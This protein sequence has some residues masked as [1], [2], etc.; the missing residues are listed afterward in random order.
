MSKKYKSGLV[1]GKFY[2]LHLGHQYIIDTAIENC[3]H[4]HVIISHN[5]TQE[6][7]GELRFQYLK[8]LY[9]DN[10]SV[11][12]HQF[13][14][15]NF[16]KYDYE[17]DTLDEFYS[18]WVPAIKSIVNDLDVVFTSEDYGDDF[19]R[20][21]GVKHHLVDRE[22]SKYPISGTKVRA[23]PFKEWDFINQDQKSFF[24]KRIAIMGP[25]S[26]GKSTLS[27][28]LSNYFNT[29]FVVEYGRTVF[30]SNGNSVTLKDFVPISEGRQ[31]LEDWIIRNSNKLVFCDTEDITTYIFLKRYCKDDEHS[32][33]ENWFKERIS[34]SKKYDLYLLLKPDCEAVQDGT[35]RFLEDRQEHYEEIKEK[36]KHYGCNFVE[37]GGDW[38][39]RFNESVKIL[40]SNFNI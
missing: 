26:V 40:K 17:C 15:D 23:N 38:N 3:E 10:N 32:K 25:E 33:E 7:P 14:D 27:K 31:S 37:I 9:K 36:L 5:K 8:D 22:R 29:N 20:Y 21:L 24:T 18:Y 1:L 39:E 34:N 35:R 6:I 30:E 13:E 12:V 2:G 11:T 16:P 4:T 28:K 19:A